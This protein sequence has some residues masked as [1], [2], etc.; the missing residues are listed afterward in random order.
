MSNKI[1]ILIK[2]GVTPTQMIRLLSREKGTI[3]Y[4][5]RIMSGKL[6]GTAI[7][8]ESLDRVIYLLG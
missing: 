3:S 1:I 6:M 5:R 4:W 8:T 7:K 2:C